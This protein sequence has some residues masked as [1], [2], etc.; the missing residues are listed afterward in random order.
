M[1]GGEAM[2]DSKDSGK[3]RRK[4]KGGGEKVREL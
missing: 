4:R 2:V 1:R 3:E